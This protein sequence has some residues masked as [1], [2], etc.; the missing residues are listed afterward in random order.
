M[1]ADVERPLETGWLADTPV[2]DSL[3]RQFLH[4]Q[5]DAQLELVR[6]VDGR[7]ERAAD[8]VLSDLGVP[9][10]MLNQA[11]LLRPLTGTDDPVLDVVAEFYRDRPGSLLSAWPT[12]DLS[13]RGW[14]LVGHPMFVARGAWESPPIVS[15]D[16]DIRSA[17]SADDLA[18]IERLAVDGYPMPEL[19]GLP[20]NSVFGA[21]LIEG[22]MTHRLGY[23]DGQPVGAAAGYVAH[24]LVNLCFAATLPAARRRGVWRSLVA[25]RCSD[26]PH[27]PAMAFTSD[28][29]RPGF[30]RL[31]F[32]PLSRA[33][34]WA[35]V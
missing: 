18:L 29:S 8:V 34:F 9:S 28:Y 19:A 15:P 22:P 16:V 35:A 12:P 10:P 4:N 31:G 30:V 26:A 3:L 13:A 24:G 14:Q 11:V 33:T 27:L 17:A 21:A 20:A 6:A 32:L 25:A 7:G 23:V 2:E 1:T 5:A